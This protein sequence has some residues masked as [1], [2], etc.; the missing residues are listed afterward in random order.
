[1]I[2]PLAATPGPAHGS[3]EATPPQRPPEAEPLRQR[4]E[5]R[6]AQAGAGGQEGAAP[7]EAVALQALLAAGAW[8][9][10]ASPAQADP[11]EQ[12]A[13]MAAA[14]TPHDLAATVRHVRVMEPVAAPHEAQ[15][16]FGLGDPMT[17]LAELRVSGDAVQGWR[18][19]LTVPPGVPQQLLAE[20][21]ERLR[22]RL[23][24]RGQRVEH[25]RIDDHEE[26]A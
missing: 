15:W 3:A 16:R 21:G 2:A 18:L 25:L 10:P 7:G 9:R 14:I 11:A 13:P 17:P 12:A 20:R 23:Q 6:L 26:E 19:Q 24:A 22:E 4:F 8:P 1:M 5:A